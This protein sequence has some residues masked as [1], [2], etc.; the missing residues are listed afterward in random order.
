M[1]DRLYRS[2]SDRMLAGVAGGLAEHWDADPSLVRIVWAVLTVFTGGIALLVYVIMAFVVPDEDSL[3]PLAGSAAPGSA[4]PGGMAP[5][6][7]EP[8]PTVPVT[9]PNAAMALLD[10]RTARA[11]ARAARRAARGPA[12]HRSAGLVFG[13]ILLVVG[14]V[15]LLEEYV[16]RFDVDQVWP[17]LLI[18]IG[19]VVLI[20]ALGGRTGD[21]GK[22]P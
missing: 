2:R 19:V 10:R 11:E 14:F 13:G 4:A 3:Y 18:G 15:F 20:S 9:D 6:G 21:V 12:S 16:P 22:A 17:L 8:G 5:V 1:N 7:P